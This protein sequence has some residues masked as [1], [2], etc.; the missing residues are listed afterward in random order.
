MVKPVLISDILTKEYMKEYREKNKERIYALT[1]K[2]Y[3]CIYCNRKD[4]HVYYK[5][6]HERTNYCLKRRNY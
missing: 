6:Q 2:T 5:K 1:Q 3:D 4:I